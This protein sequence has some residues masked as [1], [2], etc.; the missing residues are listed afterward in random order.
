MI[1]IKDTL[2]ANGGGAQNFSD[3]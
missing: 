3:I 1:S 2:P